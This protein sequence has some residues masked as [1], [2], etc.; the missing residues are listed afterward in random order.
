ML[1]GGAGYRE[2]RA[3][4][5]GSCVVEKQDVTIRVGFLEK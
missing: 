3:K 1:E 2:T 5:D 4:L